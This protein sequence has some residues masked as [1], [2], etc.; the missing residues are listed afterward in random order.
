[1]EVY[2]IYHRAK[3]KS[4]LITSLLSSCFPSMIF[5]FSTNSPAVNVRYLP[6]ESAFIIWNNVAAT[7]INLVESI[8]LFLL[9][10][11]STHVHVIVNLISTCEGTFIFFQICKNLHLS[12]LL[13]FCSY[14][15]SIFESPT[16]LS[17]LW[18]SFHSSFSSFHSSFT[19]SIN[20]ALIV[21]QQKPFLHLYC[22]AVAH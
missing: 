15:L 17:L 4:F 1:M 12:V 7:R 18:R 22:K 8:L 11:M 6:S 20:F 19:S 9:L 14:V 3:L 10:F 2:Q 13:F 5:Q 16:V 21:V